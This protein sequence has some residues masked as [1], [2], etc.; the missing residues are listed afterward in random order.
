VTQDK[1][2]SARHPVGYCLSFEAQR[3]TLRLSL[4]CVRPYRACPRD[5]PACG[6]A[7][8]LIAVLVLNAKPLQMG[9]LAVGGFFASLYVL[10]A[11]SDLRLSPA[12]LGGVIAVG[13]A[14]NVLGAWIAPRLMRRFGAGLTLI[15]SLLVMGAA[16]LMIPLAHGSVVT[17]TAF[18]MLAQVGDV[19]W[20]VFNVCEPSL[21]QAITP[22]E[23]LGRVN[24]AMQMANRGLLPIGSLGA[25]TL[26]EMIGVRPTLAVGA[27]GLLL[28]SL[29][30]VLSPIRKMRD[31][32]SVTSVLP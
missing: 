15:G 22:G 30:L 11:I 31:Y 20:P 16:S 32:N 28:S 27:A 8:P 1:F 13:G 21:R 2:R 12:L 23:V 14:G 29:W 10:Y 17:A 18:L 6:V 7:L 24:A 3:H 26:A 19:C 9:M 25:G 4:L 5:L